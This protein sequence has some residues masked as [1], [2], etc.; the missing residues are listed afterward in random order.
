M[1]SWRSSGRPSTMGVEPRDAAAGRLAVPAE[2]DLLTPARPRALGQGEPYHHAVRATAAST[3]GSGAND[4]TGAP[5]RP[6]R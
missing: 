5:L 2:D 3:V 6:S 1:S 4:R